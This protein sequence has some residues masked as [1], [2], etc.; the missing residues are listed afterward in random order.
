VPSSD[1]DL[2]D[3]QYSGSKAG[4]RPLYDVLVAAVRGLGPGVEVSP[5]KASVSLRRTKQFTLIEAASAT[6][7]RIGINL[8]GIPPN[9][10]LKAATGMC[11]HQVS[12][13]GVEDVDEELVGWLQQAYDLA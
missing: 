11:T 13:T 9:D 3:A 7:L 1:A 5:K 12:I 4:L 2:V 6:R 10:R 8:K